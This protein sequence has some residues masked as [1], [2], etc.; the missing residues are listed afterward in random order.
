MNVFIWAATDGSP[1]LIAK[2]TEL[3]AG[4]KNIQ[5]MLLILL[6]EC[7]MNAI[8]TNIAVTAII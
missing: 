1:R 5:K 3:E 8:N 7:N 2:W 6:G 4:T